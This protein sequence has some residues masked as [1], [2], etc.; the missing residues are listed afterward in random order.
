MLL[1]Q[2]KLKSITDYVL[3]TSKA[4]ETEVLI[5]ADDSALTRFANNQIHQNV[6]SQNLTVQV[7]VM[8]G[9][10]QGVASGNFQFSIFNFKLDA[11]EKRKL[12]DLVN[13]AYEI[14]KV[15][16][17]DPVFSHLP[18]KTEGKFKYQKVNAYKEKT[19]LVTPEQRAKEVEKIIKMARSSKVNAFGSLSTGTS[20]VVVANSHGIFA[21]HPYTQSLLNVRMMTDFASGYGGEIDLD[22][23]KL[24][25]EEAANRAIQKTLWGKRHGNKIEVEPWK[26]RSDSPYEVILEEPAVSE[27]MT[28]MTYLGFGARSFHEERSFMSGNLGKKVMGENITIWDDAYNNSLIP[29]PFDYQGLP[30]QKVVLI[31][32]G[33]AQNILYDHYLGL[34]YNKTPTGHG[35]PAPNTEDA[36]ATNLHLGSGT[37]PKKELLKG[38]KK[39]ILVS[40]FWYVRNVHPKELTITGM[41]RDGTFL[42][43]NGEIVGGVPNMRFTVSIPK[44]LS[45]V[46]HISREVRAEPSDEWMGASLLPSI[47][48]SEF[49]FT[50]VSKL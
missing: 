44:V 28:Y 9:K 7:R 13:Q 1:G 12:E 5:F 47:R 30:K 40:R 41:T 32:K 20:E 43:E 2:S 34:K 33:K 46:T 8:I 25:I 38:I 4:D 6:S 3:K 19:A 22:F 27:M 48:V 26:W 42:I 24:A 35:F 31:E 11:V 16:P 36:Y 21:Y 23:S 17:E 50:G 15:S 29:M 18:G 49:Q 37:T 10:K 45:S 14:A 39:G